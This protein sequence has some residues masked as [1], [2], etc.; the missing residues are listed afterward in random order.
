M[1][2]EGR[3]GVIAAKRGAVDLHE[4]P[5]HLASRSLEL[6]DSPSELDPAGTGAAEKKGGGPMATRP[7]CSMMSLKARLRVSMPA[8][9][10]GHRMVL[11]PC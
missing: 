7:T 3:H 11:R 8:F 6:N 1:T 5:L 2:E 9:R 10:T 4:V